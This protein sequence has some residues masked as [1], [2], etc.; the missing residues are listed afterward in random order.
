VLSAQRSEDVMLTTR[1]AKR[2]KT[3]RFK[4]DRR[5]DVFAFRSFWLTMPK[6]V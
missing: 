2:D 5:L 1:G 3:S 4:V 6:S